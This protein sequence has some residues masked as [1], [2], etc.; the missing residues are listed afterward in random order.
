MA[1]LFLLAL[2]VLQ[3]AVAF[4]IKPVAEYW[5][6]PD[7]LGLKYQDLT[8]TTPDRV[9]LAAWL[10]EPAAS[11]PSQHTTIVVAGGDAGNM[12]SNIF[13]AATLAGAGYQVLLFD[14]R[15]FGH[16]DA[17]AINQNYLYYPEFA[18]DTRAALAA[19]RRRSPGQRVGLMGFSMGSL[20]GSEAAATTRCD[21]LVT[22]AY[23]AS[24]QHVVAHYQRIRPERPVILPA[25]AATYS[26][27]APKVNCPWLF[28]NGTEDQATT[29]ADAQAVA[30]AASPRQ[31][32]VVLPVPG[33]HPQSMGAFIED[34]TAPRCLVALRRL[35]ASP[36]PAGKG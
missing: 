5:A 10:I 6:R 19:A 4:A 3:S 25:E 17:F 22:V 35:L 12:A 11:A 36:A 32:R 21:F 20:V 13:T 14:Y 2:L 34:E 29:L 15:G 31:H 16:S 24:P 1:R 7:T 9:H 18:T 27:V 8:L 23:A 26:R 33:D 28:I 30:K